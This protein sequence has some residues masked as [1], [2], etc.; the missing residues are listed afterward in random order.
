MELSACVG[1]LAVNQV[2]ELLYRRTEAYMRIAVS[3][4]DF[5]HPYR[6]S[7]HK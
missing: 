4:F 2:V 7:L 6:C 3:I 5:F 1:L